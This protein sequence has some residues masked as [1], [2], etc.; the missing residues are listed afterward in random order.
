MNN[1]PV[2]AYECNP[3]ARE[4]IHTVLETIVSRKLKLLRNF[5]GRKLLKELTALSLPQFGDSHNAETTEGGCTALSPYQAGIC[6]VDHERTYAFTRGVIKAIENQRQKQE[7]DT[8]IRVLYAGTGPFATLAL[9]AMNALTPRDV[10]FTLLDIQPASIANATHIVRTLGFGDFIENAICDDAI[11]H[12]PARK[13]DIVISETMTDG[14]AHEPLVL[15][16][17]NLRRY[18]KTGGDFLPED[19]YLGFKIERD[20][21]QFNYRSPTPAYRLSDTPHDRTS[22]H[23]KEKINREL[24]DCKS[25]YLTTQVKVY[26]D[27]KIGHNDSAITRDILLGASPS[28][29]MPNDMIEANYVIAEFPCFKGPTI[30]KTNRGSRIIY[31]HTGHAGCDSDIY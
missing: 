28:R 30:E 14:L 25:V 10:Q 1:N 26:R 11:T 4:G 20:N 9:P 24:P 5:A 13:Y 17:D 6:I 19:V 3:F 18:V 7:C 2:Y 27:I 15:I 31:T 8:P 23:L 16:H 12:T 22:I 21:N 29:L